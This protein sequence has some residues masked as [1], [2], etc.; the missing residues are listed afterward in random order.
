[1]L[2]ITSSNQS[3][4]CSPST[5]VSSIGDPD[6]DSDR[7]SQELL[8]SIN[9]VINS[10][11]TSNRLMIDDSQP[12][13]SPAT[14]SPSLEGS[15]FS[16][17]SS[18]NT[19]L[20]KTNNKIGKSGNLQELI[21]ANTDLCPS[22]DSA[23]ES[24]LSFGISRLLSSNNQQQKKLSA[25]SHLLQNSLNSQVQS[26]NNKLT[27]SLLGKKRSY[28]VNCNK[29]SEDE[30]DENRKSLKNKIKSLTKKRLTKV[31]SADDGQAYDELSENSN[32]SNQIKS[33][34]G[35]V[36]MSADE[37][38]FNES[39][40]MQV[41]MSRGEQKAVLKS[42]DQS[43]DPQKSF[44]SK[45]QNHPAA[46]H[47]HNL[48]P[49]ELKMVNNQQLIGRQQL[50]LTGGG[51]LVNPM[52]STP[53]FHNQQSPSSPF[54][55][56]PFGS[57]KLT[58]ANHP[59]NLNHH[60]HSSSANHYLFA[61]N[62]DDDNPRKKH[63]RNRTTFTTYQLYILEKAFAVSQYPDVYSREELA[64]QVDLPEGRIQVRNK[65]LIKKNSSHT[66]NRFS[67]PSSRIGLV[68]KSSS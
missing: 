13:S 21:D 26:T 34:P 62:G 24:R 28:Q 23:S 2:K 52:N 35:L 44:A 6:N 19:I 56:S 20:N 48:I 63:R 1:M 30:N 57:G 18:I 37:D 5:D 36:V 51:G 53:S 43:F 15:S 66:D 45:Q 25:S 11:S 12:V 50:N 41:E 10:I 65:I 4:C 59:P 60:M 7:R 49:N 67:S 40:K 55:S 29:D 22:G 68:S 61:G 64:Q 16:P 58:A 3:A 33:E 8:N 9:N 14:T 54:Q 39:N 32:C 47:P 31:K 27:S 17:N 38:S 46:Y 42:E